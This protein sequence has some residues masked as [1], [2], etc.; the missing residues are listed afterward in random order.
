MEMREVETQHRGV[1]CLMIEG[2]VAE[3]G[4]QDAALRAASCAC[5]HD[6]CRVQV[7]GLLR[8]A[9]PHRGDHPQHVRGRAE[10]AS[11]DERHVAVSS[12]GVG[13]QPQGGVFAAVRPLA[14]DCV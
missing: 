9:A 11:A 7:C 2:P 14:Q 8:G 1:C 12:P 6:D 3:H 10:G 13:Q 4:V 5:R